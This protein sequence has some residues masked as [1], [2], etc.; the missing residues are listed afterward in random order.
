MFTLRK[1][2]ADRRYELT[3]RTV[4]NNLSSLFRVNRCKHGL[5]YAA[6]FHLPIS[7]TSLHEFYA[8]KETYSQIELSVKEGFWGFD[9][10]LDRRLK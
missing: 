7:L 5:N 10:L 8:Q 4:R 3:L 2:P 6:F 9:V 1:A